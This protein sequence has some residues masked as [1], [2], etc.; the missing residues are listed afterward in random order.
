VVSFNGHWA[1]T[2]NGIVGFAVVSKIL[3]PSEQEFFFLK[4][5]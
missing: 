5:D 3:N 1:I 2:Q 4:V